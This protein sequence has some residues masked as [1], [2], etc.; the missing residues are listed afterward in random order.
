LIFYH[1][2]FNE[3]LSPRA[4]LLCVKCQVPLQR[5]P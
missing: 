2:N 1:K 5:S 3:T 4:T